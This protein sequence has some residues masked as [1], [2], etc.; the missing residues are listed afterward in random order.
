ML[1]NKLKGVNMITTS[2]LYPSIMS[3]Q[4]G[5][6]SERVIGSIECDTTPEMFEELLKEYPHFKIES[7]PSCAYYCG[8]GN[9]ALTRAISL[10]NEK[11]ADYLISK[12]GKQLINLK[13]G[14]KN[15]PLECT[16]NYYKF[17]KALAIKLIKS[18]ADVNTFH[19]GNFNCCKLPLDRALQIRFDKEI[20]KKLA[21]ILLQYGAEN[22]LKITKEGSDL[23]NAADNK[24]KW[25]F[26]VITNQKPFYKN[27]Y[28]GAKLAILEEANREIYA[29]K[30]SFF[31]GLKD[32]NS[33]ISQLP[34]ELVATILTVEE[35]V[36]INVEKK[37]IQMINQAKRTMLQNEILFK[38]A[39]SDPSSE[40]S[41]LLP[42]LISLILETRIAID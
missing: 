42:E 37:V 1:L 18:G 8:G 25:S 34:K 6:D 19:N 30:F 26:D 12:Y 11:L 16:L 4:V 27:T 39:K 31:S 21:K 32:N 22:C 9:T 3:T 41:A 13:N 28:K 38:C 7:S 20:C 17:G 33:I 29:E 2:S 10:E 5:P 23:L 40:I 24:I 14:W 35:R 36:K 15:T